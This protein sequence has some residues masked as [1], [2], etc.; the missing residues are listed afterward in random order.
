MHVVK[1]INYEAAFTKSQFLGIMDRISIFF[2]YNQRKKML[3]SFFFPGLLVS[4]RRTYFPDQRLERAP[5]LYKEDSR[6]RD[7]GTYFCP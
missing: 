3:Q 6:R 5:V 1:H 4:I 2:L 7:A